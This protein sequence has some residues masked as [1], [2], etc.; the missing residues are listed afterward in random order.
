MIKIPGWIRKG[1]RNPLNRRK[2]QRRKG[3]ETIIPPGIAPGGRLTPTGY[4]Y[5]PGGNG[6]RFGVNKRSGKDRRKNP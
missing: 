5:S 3:L 4:I 6:A 1:K 2:G